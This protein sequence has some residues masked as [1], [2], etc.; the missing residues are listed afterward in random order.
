MATPPYAVALQPDGRIVV[1]GKTQLAGDHPLVARFG[2][3][4]KPDE[5][6]GSGGWR[7]SPEYASLFSI[8]VERDGNIVAAGELEEGDESDG[9]VY[10]L[11]PTTSMF[12]K[13]GTAR[14]DLGGDEE[15]YSLALHAD[16]KIVVGGW[17]DVGA[18]PIV[19]RLRP[20]LSPDPAFGSNGSLNLGGTGFEWIHTVQVQADGKIVAAAERNGSNSD[21]VV[22]RLLGDFQPPQAQPQPGARPVPVVRCGGLKA[23]IVGTSKRDVIRGTKRRDVIAALGGNDVVR[24]NGGNDV[25]CGGAGK[26]KLVGGKGRDRLIG[27]AGKDRQIQ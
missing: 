15:A 18:D 4:G 24:G 1:A 10:R 13:E 5:S 11:P 26:D 7:S 8:A 21:I 12:A 27:G 14:L 22:T 3:D 6:F 23:T 25:I 16:G 19:W 17:T 2:T 20:D 9:V